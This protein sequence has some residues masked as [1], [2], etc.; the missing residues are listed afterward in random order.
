MLFASWHMPHPMCCTVLCAGRRIP[1]TAIPGRPAG[2]R[3]R[4]TEPK[5]GGRGCA[6]SLPFELRTRNVVRPALHS[7]WQ[8]GRGLILEEGGGGGG[9]CNGSWTRNGPKIFS[10]CKV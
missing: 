5:A 1:R 9:R 7:T 6:C 4:I 10:L 3:C 8:G 2:E